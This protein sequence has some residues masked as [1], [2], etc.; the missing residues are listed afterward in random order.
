MD[1]AILDFIQ[2]RVRSPLLD[3]VM[4]L[5]THLGD[6]ALVW[7]VVAAVLIAQPARRRYG[8]AVIAA[9]VAAA[10]VGMFVLKPLFGR[11]RPFAAHGFT[12]L[13]IPPPSGDSFPSNHSMASFAAAA[14]ICCLP[15]GG[16]GVSAL[17]A[18]AVAVA[19][20]IAVS[21]IYL[22]VHYP[23]DILAG[24]VI[25]IGIGMLSVWAVGK[26]W[27]KAPPGA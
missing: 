1:L 9:V 5:A 7:L 16:R 6:L 22:Y 24:A 21:R 8:V 18:G 2:E 23:T 13:L 3:S 20:L 10:A 25:G 4:L 11:M 27:P 19:L 26:V 12:G 14:A 15:K 17:K